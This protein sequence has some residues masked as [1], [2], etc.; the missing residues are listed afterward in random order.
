MAING[1]SLL[2]GANGYR[3]L[4]S[5]SSLLNGKTLYGLMSFLNEEVPADV[6]VEIA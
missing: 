1:L 5:K 6:K 4:G 3:S 2:S